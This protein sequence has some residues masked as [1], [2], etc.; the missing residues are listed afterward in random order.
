MEIPQ[1]EAGYEF[2]TP[3][4]TP[5]KRTISDTKTIQ[6]Q[7]HQRI[8]GLSST[9]T[10]DTFS[11]EPS[12]S[13]QDPNG[14]ST[15][16]ASNLA[17]V[18]PKA[19]EKSDNKDISGASDKSNQ[20]ERT[21]VEN[22]KPST[23]APAAIHSDTPVEEEI[24][25]IRHSANIND[26]TYAPLPY[27]EFR[28]TWH[29]CDSCGN[30]VRCIH[31]TS[32]AQSS[33][34]N[35]VTS[36]EGQNQAGEEDPTAWN[37][38]ADYEISMVQ[39]GQDWNIP[40]D[41]APRLA[42]AAGEAE[43]PTASR[44]EPLHLLV[45]Y[46]SRP[47]PDPSGSRNTGQRGA[48]YTIVSCILPSNPY[49]VVMANILHRLK[50]TDGTHNP[51]PIAPTAQIDYVDVQFGAIAAHA[52][53]FLGRRRIEE[54]NVGDLLNY[55]RQRQGG[56]D[57]LEVFLVPMNEQDPQEHVPKTFEDWMMERGTDWKG[58][59]SL[60]G[61][62]AGGETLYYWLINPLKRWVAEKQGLWTET[63]RFEWKQWVSQLW[64]GS[65]EM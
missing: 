23:S 14:E 18:E 20:E 60:V 13:E 64:R 39:S 3:P 42:E 36:G 44:E 54:D 43:A 41:A 48:S 27:E 21:E 47:F 4:L 11:G 7:A 58:S 35:E 19:E 26:G 8:E 37:G 61:K 34:E 45:K 46:D 5:V 32:Q 56:D 30:I 22:A 40:W 2:P 62:M 10:T 28:D 24:E 49:P 31:G 25:E 53:G 29:I 52:P 57:I 17:I 9:A 15:T 16:Q 38:A 6:D 33:N 63:R 50:R 55:L 12:T 1:Q 59:R 65:M 51:Y